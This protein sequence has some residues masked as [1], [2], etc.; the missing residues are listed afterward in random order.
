MKGMELAGALLLVVGIVP[1]GRASLDVAAPFA[2]GM[3][4]QRDRPVP[5]WGKADPGESVTVSFAGQTKSAVADAS[6]LWRVA[7]D[8]MPASKESRMLAVATSTVNLNI[9]DV[10]VGEVWL[11]SGQ[12]NADLPIWGNEVRYRDG[13]GALMLRSTV[14]PFVRLVK[15]K[16]VWMTGPNTN[17]ERAVWRKM[18]PELFAAYKKGEKLPSAMGYYYALEL[19]NALDV[20]IGLVD[21][22]QGGT[23]IDAWTPRSG[24]ASHP[25]LKDVADY[26]L[27]SGNWDPAKDRVGPISGLEEQPTVLWNGLVAP[28]AP[29]AIRGFIWYQGCH[30]VW[31]WSR[32]AAK[33]HALYDGWAKEFENPDLEFYFAQIAWSNDA[34]VRL[35]I[36]QARFAAEE[37]HAAMAVLSDA[38][39]PHD[40]H[41]ND[42]R[43]VAK[44][45]SLHALK[46]LYGFGEIENESPTVTGWKVEGARVTLSFDHADE[47]WYVYNLDNTPAN[48]FELAGADGVFRPARIVN[49]HENKKFVCRWPFQGTNIVL[50]A[51]GVAEPHRARYLFIKPWFGSVYTGAGLP[52]GPFEIPSFT[53]KPFRLKGKWCSLGTSITWLDTHQGSS[54]GGM[55]R[56]YQSRVQDV[57]TFDGYVNCGVN[58]AATFHQIGHIERA[59]WYTIEHGIND[60]GYSK[61]VGT[62]DDYR[63]KATNLTFCANYRTIVD[64]IRALNPQARIVVCTPRRGYGFGTYLPAHSD[65]PKNGIYLKD[66]VEAVRAIAKEEGFPLVDF[67]A[68]CGANDELED[69]SY[70]KAL[71]PN[72]KGYQRMAEEVIKVFERFK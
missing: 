14:K 27:K 70:D 47:G 48:G 38:G 6:G 15:V 2:D 19:A 68:T 18:T 12:S 8:P 24:Y 62:I 71:H 23:N 25:E 34:T 7:L 32:Y 57:V 56:G 37:P 5:V 53:H 65:V 64:Q 49:M 55:T 66:Y 67:Y 54:R 28:Y 40:I 58:G 3:V 41:P 36:E 63:N 26:P 30:N 61:P 10:L 42:K 50:E 33:M 11:C 21:A 9:M 4:L 20:P 51:D 60:W 52:L 39:N 46:R 16:Q 69:L 43:V 31:D 44:R 17:A 29:M 13:W 1:A 35:K 22:S 59:D 72:D 45:L